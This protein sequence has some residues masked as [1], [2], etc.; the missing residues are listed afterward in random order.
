[1]VDQPLYPPA[2][3]EPIWLALGLTLIGVAVGVAL[4]R[5]FPPRR[6]RLP[7]RRATRVRRAALAQIDAVESAHRA[8]RLDA[9]GAA[10]ELSQAVRRFAADWTGMLYPAMTL[11]ELEERAGPPPLQEIVERLYT[12]AFAGAPVDVADEAARARE[13][14]TSW[15][16]N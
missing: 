4:L 16:R 11:A 2:P 1:M 3:Y 8:G 15:R 5:R 12:A 9:S 10:S 7:A 6:P 13:V 14:V